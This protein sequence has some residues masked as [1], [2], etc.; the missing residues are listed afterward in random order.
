[1]VVLGEEGAAGALYC[2]V[3]RRGDGDQTPVDVQERRGRRY[4]AAIGIAVPAHLV[5]ADQR[6]SVWNPGSARPGWSRLLTAVRS[7]R[8]PALVVFKPAM[9]VR[10]RAADA[11]ELLIAAQ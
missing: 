3:P 2:C 11:V 5:F 6:R 9:L 4:A 8:V 7:G 1:M 10:H